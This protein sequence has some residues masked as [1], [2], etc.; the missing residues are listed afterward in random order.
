MM[1]GYNNLQRC[2]ER[3]N[4]K[5]SGCDAVELAN[6]Y[7]TPLY[8]MDEEDIVERCRDIRKNHILKYGGIAVY[9]SKAFCNKE[10]CRIMKREG[11]GLDVV[12]GGEMYTAWSAGFPMEKVIFHGNNKSYDELEMA[13]KLGVGRVTID[14]FYEIELVEKILK[15]NNAHLD[16]L[17]RVAPGVDPHTHSYIRTGQID[18]KFGFN[19]FNKDA[20]EAVKIIEE[21]EYM[22]FKGLHSH[23]GSQLDENEIYINEIKVLAELAE[24]IKNEIGR[25]MDELDVG[26]GFGIF[27]VNGDKRN[28][29]SFYTDAINKTVQSEFGKRDMKSPTVIIE[30]GRWIVG[31]AGVTLY[32]A[33]AI[34]EIEG[35]RK[36]VSVD[37][38]MADN[39]R[40]A[41]YQAKYTAVIANAAE[42]SKTEKITLAGKCCE[43]GDVLIENIKLDEIH[44]GDIIAVLSTG[45]YNYSMSSNYNRLPKPAVVMVK[46]GEHRLIV[47]RETYEDIVRN[48]I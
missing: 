5:I 12:S 44:S 46:N 20:I 42:R 33:G 39:P 11:L 24:K 21:S 35:I 16:V 4:M 3:E 36:Y 7:K 19:V 31:E 1:L 10:M 47:K 15:E 40:P 26:G 22:T 17:L 28:S 2:S 48:D 14:N 38:G 27:Y 32:T 30:P 13:V 23:A 18:S 25:D 6:I 43:S 9:A 45:A 8:V 41:L 29:I 34:K 37:G